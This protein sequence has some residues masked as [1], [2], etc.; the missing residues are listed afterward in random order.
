MPFDGLPAVFRPPG[1]IPQGQPLIDPADP[2]NAGLASAWLFAGSPLDLSGRGNRGTPVG[3]PGLVPSRV[4]LAASFNGSSQYV[5]LPAAPFASYS[6]G[7]IVALVTPATAL[8]NS[9]EEI[10]A[11][12]SPSLGYICAFCIRQNDGVG[13][14][15]RLVIEWET[16]AGTVYALYGN[17]I[18]VPG[19]SH[20][21]AVVASGSE[22]QLYVDGVSQTLTDATGAGNSGYWFQQVGAPSPQLLIGAVNYGGVQAYFDGAIANCRMFARPLLPTEIARL[23]RDPFA[24]LLFPSDRLWLW[25]TAASG[26]LS[27]SAAARIATEVA[28]GIAHAATLPQE[29]PA[30]I[31]SRIDIAAELQSTIAPQPALPAEWLAGRL[32]AVPVPAE[33]LRASDSVAATPAEALAALA[34]GAVV[35]IENAGAA[36]LIVAVAA[37]LPLEW[38]QAASVPLPLMRLLA[39]PARLRVLSPA[40]RR[41]L[42]ASPG[43]LRTLT[44]TDR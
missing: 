37:G 13:A 29:A 14:G 17:T 43:R 7:A 38:R 5:S 11:F 27:V 15:N 10:V 32:R 2:I 9:V 1:V 23:Y 26:G 19:G 12:G 24:G 4:G 31:A 30:T 28:S 6:A 21:V 42:L 39:S 25:A 3:S 34:A 40:A 8:S 44:P 33:W 22:W 18:L 41:R 35:A 16:G 20:V 36:T